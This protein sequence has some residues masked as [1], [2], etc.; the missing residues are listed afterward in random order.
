MVNIKINHGRRPII[1]TI[2]SIFVLG[3]SIWW[4]VNLFLHPETITNSNNSIYSITKLGVLVSS[5][6]ML[7]LR[8]W[9]VY[10]YAVTYIVTCILFF[11]LDQ[12][13]KLPEN[14]QNT[15]AG[16]V[17][18]VVTILVVFMFRKYWCKLK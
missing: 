9:G 13:H 14:Q 7:L 15:I 11:V 6:G 5:I 1:L 8:K 10:L 4:F 12:P 16:I 2:F 3:S 18:V 17:I